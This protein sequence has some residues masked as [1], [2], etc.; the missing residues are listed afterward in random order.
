M[1]T[2]LLD[3][4]LCNCGHRTPIHPAMIPTPRGNQKWIEIAD[5]P[6][7]FLCNGCK[8]LYELDFGRL[9]TGQDLSGLAPYNPDAPKMRCEVW[10][11]C[12]E[13]LNCLPIKVIAVL[14]ADTTA[15]K[16]EEEQSTWRGR[17]LRCPRGHVQSFPAGWE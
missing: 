10:L 8:R 1:N 16:L 14:K 6:V 13:E 11:P 15:K 5:S 4:A 17:A 12:A 2:F 3:F 9:V 7:F